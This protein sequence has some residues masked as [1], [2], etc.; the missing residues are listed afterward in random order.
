MGALLAHPLFVDKM[1]GKAD[2]GAN[3]GL[4]REV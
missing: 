2:I 3:G 4:A 1:L